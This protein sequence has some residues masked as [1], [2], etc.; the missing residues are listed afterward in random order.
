MPDQSMTRSER[1]IVSA[2]LID[3]YTLNVTRHDAGSGFTIQVVELPGCIAV[4]PTAEGIRH[5]IEVAIAVHL[6]A[7][8]PLTKHLRTR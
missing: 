8:R 4:S 1:G 7:L 3:G 5:A 6:D 2:E